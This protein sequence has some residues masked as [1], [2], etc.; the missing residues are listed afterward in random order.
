M[1]VHKTAIVDPKAKLAKDV[2][3][4]PYSSVG[5]NVTIGAGTKI[6][7]ACRLEGFTAIGKNCQIF[8]GAVIGSIPQDLKFKKGIK[9][10]VKIGDN[11]TIREYVTINPGTGEGEVTS[12]GNGNLLMAYSHVA[13]NCIVGNGV[14]MANSGTLAGHVT[15]EDKAVLG[16]LGGVHQFV[17]VGELSIIGG[18]SKAA[19]DIL[20]YYLY[21][22]QRAAPYGLNVIGLKRAGV[23]RE[24]R[25]NLKRAF[26]ILLNLGLSVPS[27][28][29]KIKQE[30]PI[31]KEITHLIE[32]VG[33][34]QRGIAR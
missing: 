20:P 1:K 29:K 14:I 16:G 19:Q 23:S 4:G 18:C 24:V 7:Q 9:S 33:S 21:D 15:I 25:E 8:T 12:L 5:A 17:R 6:G 2:E 3:V 27:A 28:L 34:S 10:F 13:H 30:I 11:N 31:S 26:K 22:G 32:F